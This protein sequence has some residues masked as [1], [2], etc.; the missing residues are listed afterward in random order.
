MNPNK[1]RI[2]GVEMHPG[3]LGYSLFEPGYTQMPIA[4]SDSWDHLWTLIHLCYDVDVYAT[5]SHG[6]HKFGLPI[7]KENA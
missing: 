3:K 2:E 4:T 1:W 6:R 7:G 5:T